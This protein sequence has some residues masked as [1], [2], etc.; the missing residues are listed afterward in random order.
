MLSPRLAA[1]LRPAG[2]V[3][4]ARGPASL[5]CG[6]GKQ[7]KAL[8][9]PATRACNTVAHRA[10][11]QIIHAPLMTALLVVR[12]MLGACR[13]ACI[14]GGIVSR[15]VQGVLRSGARAVGSGTRALLCWAARK[16]VPAALL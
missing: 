14:M 16:V 7:Q 10:R 15:P 1:C 11:A 9:R 5:L 4:P 2:S 8:L 13:D 12:Q 3:S 6:M